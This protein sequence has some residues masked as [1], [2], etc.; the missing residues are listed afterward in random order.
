MSKPPCSAKMTNRGSN[1]SPARVEGE[2]P[3]E[4]NVA[5]SSPSSDFLLDLQPGSHEYDSTS[6][7]SKYTRSWPSLDAF[8]TWLREYEESTSIKHAPAKKEKSKN[9]QHY[10]WKRRYA[11][12]Y[13]PMVTNEKSETVPG[14]QCPSVLIVKAYPGTEEIRGHVT[15]WHRHDISK[16]KNIFE[17]F[18][19]DGDDSDVDEDGR[20]SVPAYVKVC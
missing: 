7:E 14:E 3:H 17:M 13:R 9:G 12:T 6:P 11:C 1:A 20:V 18:F 10:L 15:T 2:P 16:K 19:E 5:E 4:S 8:T